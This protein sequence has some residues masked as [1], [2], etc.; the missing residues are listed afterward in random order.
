[1]RILIVPNTD[2]VRAPI[3]GRMNFV[4]ERIA[5]R[6]EV[7]VAHFQYDMFSDQ[8]ERHTCCRLIDFGRMRSSNLAAEYIMHAPSHLLRFARL[9]NGQ[10]Y[11]VAVLGNLLPAHI[12][13]ALRGSTRIIVDLFDRFDESAKMHYAD[14]PLAGF[15]VG[16]GSRM[17][18]NHTLKTADAVVAVAE[19]DIAYVRQVAGNRAGLHIIPNGIDTALFRPMDKNK[20][21]SRLGLA[22][23]TVIGFTGLLEKWIDLETIVELM[24]RIRERLGDVR[25]LIVGGSYYCTYQQELRCRIAD[26]GLSHFVVLTGTVPYEDVPLYIGAMDVCLNPRQPLKMN[27]GAVSN[28]LLGYLACGRPVLSTNNPAAER[29]FRHVHEY[30]RD[31]FIDILTTLLSQLPPMDTVRAETQGY[32]WNEIA[33][34]FEQVLVGAVH[35]SRPCLA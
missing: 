26:L 8:Q 4:F 21:K 16:E 35:R 7:H 17:I 9:L 31:T 30:T 23:T 24:P 22:G 20:A 13:T 5:K 34:R 32:D 33:A 2:W 1:M 19:D 29:L 3:T 25:L 11:D 12:V 6:Q 27:R 10:K 28:K 15:F 14:R 18:L